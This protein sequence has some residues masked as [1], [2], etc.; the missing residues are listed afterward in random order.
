MRNSAEAIE[1][2]LLAYLNG[3]HVKGI[4]PNEI[5]VVRKDLETLQKYYGRQ[6]VILLGCKIVRTP[7]PGSICPD[8]ESNP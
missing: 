3:L 2:R 8:G 1:Q 4:K 7:D 6:D 5:P